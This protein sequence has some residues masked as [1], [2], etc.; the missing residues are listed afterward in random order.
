MKKVMMKP[1]K[2]KKPALRTQRQVNL[3]K[4]QA[5]LGYIM[6]SRLARIK[7]ESLSQN[8]KQKRKKNY[9]RMEQPIPHLLFSLELLPHS[10][11]TIYQS[12]LPQSTLLSGQYRR[13]LWY[14]LQSFSKYE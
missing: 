7:C 6:S 3:C 2:I 14:L 13:S 1:R 8:S 5:S 11:H 10:V 9:K 4:T 12:L